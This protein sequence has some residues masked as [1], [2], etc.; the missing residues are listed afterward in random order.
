MSVYMR[1]ADGA[2]AELAKSPGLENVGADRPFLD[3]IVELFKELAPLLISC[4]VSPARA[5]AEAQNPRLITRARLRLHLRNMLRDEDSVRAFGD[6]LFRAVL[7]VG[8]TATEQDFEEVAA[9]MS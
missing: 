3:M 2:Q 9:L 5:A 1:W 7:A 4:F 8:R 6:P